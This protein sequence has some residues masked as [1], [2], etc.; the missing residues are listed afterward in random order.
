MRIPQQNGHGFHSKMDTVSTAKWTRFPQQN[1]H[2]FHSKV[3]TVFTA[4][5]TVKM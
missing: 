2:G 1:G 4:K 5:W 3:D